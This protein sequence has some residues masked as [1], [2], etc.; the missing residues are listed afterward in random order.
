MLT[1]RKN[2]QNIQ[3]GEKGGGE[4]V[5]RTVDGG[6]VCAAEGPSIARHLDAERVPEKG[7]ELEP[8]GWLLGGPERVGAS[9]GV[10]H[11][12]EGAVGL[13]VDERAH[14]RHIRVDAVCA[15][16]H[17]RRKVAKDLRKDWLVLLVGDDAR[18]ESR[19]VDLGDGVGP[20]RAVGDEV[21]RHGPV[22]MTEIHRV[23]V[24]TVT[25]AALHRQLWRLDLAGRVLGEDERLNPWRAGRVGVGG[26]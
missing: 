12:H 18:A 14:P 13:R 10:G 6:G 2:Q 20:A 7:V 23:D 4:E 22:G 1:K 21:R 5:T 15:R 8:E 11:P 17:I 19:G 26:V 9:V 3:R 25:Y 16:G 24:D